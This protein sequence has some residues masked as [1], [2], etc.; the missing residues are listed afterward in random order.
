MFVRVTTI[1][2]LG[3]LDDDA[4][5]TI[6]DVRDSA[7]PMAGLEGATISVDR[8]DGSMVVA[9]WWDSKEHRAASLGRRNGAIRALE[10]LLSRG[11][12]NVTTWEGEVAIFLP[13][14]DGALTEVHP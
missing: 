13:P 5:A 2:G 12:A 7:W 6:G 4:M 14:S 8:R 11:R 1:T 10:A 3:P 9:T